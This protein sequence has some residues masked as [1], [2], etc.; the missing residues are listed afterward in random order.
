M[1]EA[2]GQCLFLICIIG[3]WWSY[4]DTLMFRSDKRGTIMSAPYFNIERE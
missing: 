1:I 3:T 4:P 2:V